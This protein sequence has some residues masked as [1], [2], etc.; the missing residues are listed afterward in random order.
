M[1]LTVASSSVD[2]PAVGDRAVRRAL[3]RR[4]G[5][6]DEPVVGPR[7]EEHDLARAPGWSAPS[8]AGMR[9]RGTT[10][11]A[12]RLG[13]MR[14]RRARERVVR[15]GRPDAGRVDDRARSGCRGPSPVDGRRG[16]SALER[17][18]T[19]VSLSQAG[20]PH[21]GDG[22]GRASVG[23]GG[24]HDGQRE[25]GVVLHPVVVEQPAAQARRG[26]RTGRCPASP[27]GPGAGASRRRGARR[28]RRTGSA[29]RRRTPWSGTGGRRSGRAA[30]RA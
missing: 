13:R 17:H 15:V 24:P 26:A 20:R 8:L 2:L 28:A 9:S 22:D 14:H 29:R 5:R 16:Q 12:P 11:W 27:L 30:A 19:R 4:V 1:A 23:Q 25:P 3:V 6:A 7:H 21:P 10:R 18:R